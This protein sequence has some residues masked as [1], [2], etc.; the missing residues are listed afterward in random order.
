[1]K[2]EE[3]LFL[4]ILNAAL[5]PENSDL[6]QE[7]DLVLIQKNMTSILS[8]A[9]NHKILPPVYELLCRIGCTFSDEEMKSLLPEI[10]TY[11]L[12]CHQMSRFTHYVCHLF[13]DA[14]IPFFLLKGTTLSDLYPKPEFRRFGDIDLLIN[15]DR[16]FQK[17][18]QLLLEHGF[19]IRKDLVDHHVEFLLIRPER[20]YLLELHRK[21][22]ASQNSPALHRSLTDI[23]DN[24]PTDAPLPPVFTALYLLLHMLQHFFS[25]GFGIK[26][27]CDWVVYLEH[28]TG[29]IPAEQLSDLL[30]QL[31]LTGFAQTI[32]ELCI[33]D[34]GLSAAPACLRFHSSA[35]IPF[36]RENEV[37]DH[38]AD[39]IFTAGEFGKSDTSRMLIIRKSSHPF[40]YLRE[41]HHQMQNRY[42]A[43]GRIPLLW[44][45]LWALTGY[46]FLHNNR[47]LRRTSTR[48]ILQSA[49]DRQRLAK[50][51]N[52]RL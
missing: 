3:Q 13:Q 48:K 33:R 31:G 42:S 11:A 6:L 18:Q 5:H 37:M 25:S 41:F 47:H 44:P 9:R 24:I 14:G 40:H 34:L 26:L 52:I 17:A 27:L 49:K 1:M 51:M 12:S 32:T 50:E 8:L 39:D 30:Q 4:H 19:Q 28:E 36:H 22:I 7:P 35:E 46:H 29:N 45:I 10:S 16:L 21:V 20:T 38:L 23:Y 43:S 2:Q 15:N